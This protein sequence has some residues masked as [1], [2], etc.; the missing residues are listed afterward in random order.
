[1]IIE[2]D[3]SV[4]E[5]TRLIDIEPIDLQPGESRLRIDQFALT[6]N[7]ITYG[8]FGDMLR[9]W[10]VFP[11]TESPDEWGRI[12][13][14]GFA[15]VVESRCEDLSVG[16]RFFGFLPMASETIITPGR[17]DDRGVTDIAAHRSDLPGAYNRYQRTTSDPSYDSG[18][19]HHQMILYPLFFTSFVIDDFLIDNGDFGAEQIVISSASSK[20]AIGVAFLAKARGMKTIGL[21]SASNRAFV[22]SLDVYA[23]VIAYEEL[24]SVD[25]VR[26]VYVDIAGN[27]DLLRSVHSHL[28]GV[29]EHSMIVGNTNWNHTPTDTG[30]LAPPTPEF[31]F[32]PTQ[33]AKRSKEWGGDELD[34]RIS[35]A[36]RT[37]SA[38]T[39]TWIE[40]VPV[41]GPDA[42]VAVYET[43]CSG[44]PDPRLGYI[45]SLITEGT[46]HG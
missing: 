1:M 43:L 28:S 14:W 2:T 45:C 3:R 32:A 13:V 15:E 19:E 9:Y 17:I 8:V 10:R 38:W 25:R 27:Q 39:D 22:E 40:F 35:E 11:A 42:V 37:Y 33:I 16:E 36:W 6:T 7:N 29:L 30:E 5:R 31:L 12:P 26:S 23:E 46:T 24:E 34:R 21:T 44:R 41:V 18:R 4:L 20:T